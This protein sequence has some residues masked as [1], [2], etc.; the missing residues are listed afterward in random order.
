MFTTER[1]YGSRMGTAATSQVGIDE[2][3]A[4]RTSFVPGH[5]PEPPLAKDRAVNRVDG[6]ERFVARPAGGR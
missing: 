5:F 1:D 6:A 2:R 3:A 4:L